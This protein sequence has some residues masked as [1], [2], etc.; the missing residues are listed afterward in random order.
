MFALYYTLP[1]LFSSIPLIAAQS[2]SEDLYLGYTRSVE[3]DQGSVVY[4]TAGTPYNGSTSV[5]DPDVFLNA[6]VHV[7]E[8]DLTVTNLTAKI[9]LAA[10]VLS[11]LNFN[12]GVD[13]SID[14]VELLIENVNAHVLLE[15]RLG[16]LVNMIDDVMNSLD[17]NPLLATLGSAVTNITNATGS[18]LGGALGGLT[19][20]D[21]SSTVSARSLN[22]NIMHNILYSVNNYQGDTHTNRILAQN[23]DLVDESLDNDGHATGQKTVGNYKTA[24]TFNGFSKAVET[25]I[26]GQTATKESEYNYNPFPGLTVISMIYQNAAGTVVG[27]RVL[28]EGAG[29]GSSTIGDEA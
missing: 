24:M 22:Y 12:A 10:Q 7:S 21:N 13:V 27:T 29:G 25:T 15:A 16:N 26:N 2:S 28:S 1:L 6:S 4:D 19:G 9:N 23:G 5:P 18:A 8:I 11:L 20:S 3:G 17:L 14:E